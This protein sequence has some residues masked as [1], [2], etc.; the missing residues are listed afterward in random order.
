[1]AFA[2]FTGTRFSPLYDYAVGAA[3]FPSAKTLKA[4][5]EIVQ[6]KAN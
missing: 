5:G 6:N 3:D 1:V 2:R 4:S